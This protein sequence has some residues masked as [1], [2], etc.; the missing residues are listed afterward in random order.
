MSNNSGHTIS[1]LHRAMREV[2]EG[3]GDEKLVREIARNSLRTL[4][5]ILNHYDGRG[6]IPTEDVERYVI[7]HLRR[8]ISDLLLGDKRTYPPLLLGTEVS[9]GA[10]LCGKGDTVCCTLHSFGGDIC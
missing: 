8:D 4:R 6:L 3:Y 7:A 5:D 2:E 10:S 1:Y 9:G